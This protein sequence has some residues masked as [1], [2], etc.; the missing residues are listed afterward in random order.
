MKCPK[1]NSTKTR[2]NGH[3]RGQQCFQ[4]RVCGRQFV[5]SPKMPPYSPQIK[6]LCLKIYVNGMGLRGIERVTEIHHTT[7][8]KWIKEAG[9]KLP[10][11]PEDEEIPE[12]TEIDELQTYLGNKKNKV[13]I[14]TVVNHW[15]QGILSWVRGDLLTQRY[16]ERS[17][18]N[19]QYLWSIIRC[20]HSFWYVSDGY[21][22]IPLF[23]CSRGSRA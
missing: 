1:C 19:F 17:H 16:R 9:I 7:V 12:I 6:E 13:G 4:C 5:E 2:K 14:W 10:D 20:W 23:Y 22:C 3:R 18:K 8:I 15:K 11:A 21:P